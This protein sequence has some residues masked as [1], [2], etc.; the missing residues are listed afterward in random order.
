MHTA[1]MARLSLALILLGVPGVVLAQECSNQREQLA[2]MPLAERIYHAASPM[3]APEADLDTLAKLLDAKD[4]PGPDAYRDAKGR[5]ALLA[6]AMN[7]R[8]DAVDVLLEHGAAVEATDDQGQNALMIAAGNVW[9]DVM[10]RLLDAPGARALNLHAADKSGNTAVS[11]ATSA[12]EYMA[13]PD[14]AEAVLGMLAKAETETQPQLQEP[15][16]EL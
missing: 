5:T 14:R 15:R 8:T 11:L 16:V 6:A 10:R 3:T 13:T 1:C 2:K 7:G 4:S 12:K 9:P